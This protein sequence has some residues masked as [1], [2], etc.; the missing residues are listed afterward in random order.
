MS[1]VLRAVAYIVGAVV[2][3][4]AVH[5]YVHRRLVVDAEVPPRWRAPARAL[6]FALATLLPAGMVGLLAM[7][8]LPRSA[9][10]PLMLCAFGWVGAL[11][12]LL[13]LLLVSEP[14]RTVRDPER[15]RALARVI[16]IVSGAATLGLSGTAVAVARS[17][18]VVRRERVSLPL[19]AYPRGYR[20]VQLSDL[21]VSA[22]T[23][24]G[25]V[26][27]IVATVLGLEPDLIA[28]TGD[29]VDGSVREL[30][31]LVA[32]LANLRARDGI[33]F[34]TGNHEYLSGVDEWLAFVRLIGVR[35]LRNERVAIGGEGGFDLIGVDDQAGK[36][37]LP[38]HG[39]DLA[40]A[41]NGR[42]P[43]RPSILLA[44]R[45]DDVQEAA[46]RGID[47]QLSGH[48]HGG[49]IFPAWWLAERFHQPYV[50]G[51]H[52]VGNTVL[53][54]TSGAG[55]WGPPMRLGA[56]AEIM[57]FELHQPDVV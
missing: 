7:H 1:G 38:D 46:R 57:V 2:L 4:T 47:V 41:T 42:D 17:S 16:G 49:Q 30:G 29:L 33:Y 3:T 20:I 36:S 50:Y 56:R 54:V 24:V 22:T 14:L 55:T 11:M 51:L 31:P 35:V 10:A 27:S 32:P 26:A 9:A 25:F 48:T 21:H 43:R 18:P 23:R 52:R 15:R 45:P 39:T 13:P 5:V 53:H 34:V 40:A 37:W 8:D 44:H 12:F 28:I 19:R 6:T